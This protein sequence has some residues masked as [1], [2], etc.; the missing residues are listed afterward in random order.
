MLIAIDLLL[1]VTDDRTG[2]VC[3]P[4]NQIDIALG[5]AGKVWVLVPVAMAAGPELA[6]RLTGSEH[7]DI[8]H[9]RVA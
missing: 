9:A 3:V 1:L 6:G 2:K 8:R 7:P 4:S 5:G